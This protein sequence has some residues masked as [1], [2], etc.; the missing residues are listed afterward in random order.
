MR[1]AGWRLARRWC[2]DVTRNFKAVCV[3]G[4]LP[5]SLKRRAFPHIAEY[6]YETLN[7]TLHY[8]I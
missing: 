2:V 4:R 3:T 5:I 8:A 1:K 7:L 6:S